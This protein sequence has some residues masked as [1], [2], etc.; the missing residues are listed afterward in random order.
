M[1]PVTR[2][3]HYFRVEGLLIRTAVYNIGDS[4]VANRINFLSELCM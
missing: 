3:R 1:W 2:L 4:N